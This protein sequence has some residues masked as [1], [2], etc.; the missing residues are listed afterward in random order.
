MT[1]GFPLMRVLAA[2]CVRH[3]V[4]VVLLWVVTLVLVT[5]MGRDLG[6]NYSDNLT[7]PHTQSTEAIDLLKQ[8]SPPVSGDT[9][10]I[11]FASTAGPVTEPAVSARIEAMLAEVSRLPHVTRI[12]SPYT[13]AGHDQISAHGRVA[14][15]SVTY[16]RSSQDLPGHAAALLVH[17][18]RSAD[19]PGLSVAV[20]GTLA[21]QSAQ[22]ALGDSWLGIVLAGVVLLLVFGSLYAMLLPLVSA[23]ASLGRP[24][25]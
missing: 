5:L 17:T 25:P 18:A 1:E 11:V 8:A 22:A 23:L 6:T 12:V 14:F 19:R 21:E 9:E 15:A 7:L 20:A 16:D 13:A 24:S 3:R 2:W 4:L 10:Q